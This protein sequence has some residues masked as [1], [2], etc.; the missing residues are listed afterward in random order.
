[1]K[2]SSRLL[3][4]GSLLVFIVFSGCGTPSS[5][6]E[7]KAAQQAM[8]SAEKAHAESL[9]ISN[10]NEAVIAWDQ[11]QA[12]VQEG[13][14]AKTYFLRAKSRFEKAEAIA[15][16]T[17]EKM[18][19]EVSQMQAGIAEAL[20]QVKAELEKGRLSSRVQKQIR[21]MVEEAD[22]GVE[23]LEKLVTDGDFKNARDLAK[24]IQSKI[25]NARLIAAGKKPI[26]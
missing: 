22:R 2:R 9:A 11:A 18:S 21:P 7:M 13:K 3:I 8:E 1:M 19:R 12:A 17:G 6:A 10:W 4:G 20:S 26:Y 5:E 15:K 24:E 14:S 16:S 25:Y 23:A